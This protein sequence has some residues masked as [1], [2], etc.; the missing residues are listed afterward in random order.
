MAKI[1]FY[2][3]VHQPY[4][5]RYYPY[6]DIGHHHNY[7]DEEKNKAILLKVAEKCYLPAN[8]LLL[9]LIKKF[10]GQFKV[11]FSISGTAID[12]FKSYSPETLDSF[13]RL[14]DTGCVEFLAETYYHSLCFLFSVEEF[15]KQLHQHHVCIEKEFGYSP[16]TFRNTELIYNNKLSHLIE[17]LGYSTILAEG[18]DKILGWRSPNLIYHPT[19]CTQLKLLLKNYRL[20]DDIAFR[21]SDKAWKE[22]PLT[23]EKFAAWL[24]NCQSNCEVINLFMDYETFGEHHWK[25][26]GI[27]AFLEKLPEM[28]LKNPT[29]S[30]T[31]PAEIS[32]ITTPVASLD[33]PEFISWAD[34]DRDLSAWRGNEL[35]E[36]ALQTIYSLEKDVLNLD[37]PASTQTWRKLQTSDHFYYM[38]IKFATDGDVHQYFSAYQNPYEAYTNYQNVVSDFKQQLK[39]PRS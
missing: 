33:I 32:K 28:I 10:Q 12:Q 5:L 31:T 19:H 11:S 25:E 1:C 21:F 37:H 9:S 22:Y 39:E 2:F 20:S 26:T 18:A 35:Q 14:A 7:F 15:K 34:V 36:D 6:F 23:A 29:F 24:H 38:C 16:K 13:K 8:A 27:F 17:R 3:Q 4:R 30:F